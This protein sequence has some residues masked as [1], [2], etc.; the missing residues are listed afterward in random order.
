MLKELRGQSCTQLALGKQRVE[1]LTVSLG[2][3]YGSLGAFCIWEAR[4]LVGFASCRDSYRIVRSHITKVPS[5]ALQRC[6]V[7]L[8][9]LHG[10]PIAALNIDNSV[11]YTVPLADSWR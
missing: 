2:D 11:F 8:Q 3:Q 10:V 9:C 4:R 7:L 5:A 1:K 6:R